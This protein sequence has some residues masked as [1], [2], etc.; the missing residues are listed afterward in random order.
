MNKSWQGKVVLIAAVALLLA[1]AGSAD[2]VTDF[3][4]PD[5]NG[6]AA[7]VVLAGQ[8]GWYNPVAGCAD[9]YVFTYADNAF[10]VPQNPTGD[11]QFVAGEHGDWA[12]S[13]ARAEHD[14]TYTEEIWTVAFDICTRNIGEL[15]ALDNLGSYSFQPFGDYAAPSSRGCIILYTWFDVNT[16]TNWNVSYVIYDDLGLPTPN[17]PP[18]GAYPDPAWQNLEVDHWYRLSH[19]IDYTQNRIVEVSITDLNTNDTT[20]VTDPVDPATGA[21]FYLGGGAN[22]GALPLPTGFRFFTGGGVSDAQPGNTVA[23]DNLVVQ[24]GGGCAGDLDGDGDTDQSDLGILLADWGCTS[25]CP[26]DL[27]GD[28]DTDQSDLGILLADWGCGT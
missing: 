1:A 16:A 25:D 17:Y 18:V 27:D 12:D 4:A 9:Y 8:Q 11:D 2:L 22:P 10:G 28:D 20:T 15:P 3:E 23:C 26:G 5:Y 19:I 14:N 24:P 13:H 7:G 6:S 21:Q